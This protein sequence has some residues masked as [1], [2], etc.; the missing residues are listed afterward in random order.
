[1]GLTSSSGGR[2]AAL[3]E[4]TFPSDPGLPVVALAGSPNVG[5]STVFNALTGLRQHT[6]NWTGKTV[7]LASGRCR[8]REL[9]L[10]DLPGCFSLEPSSREE[11]VARDFLISGKAEAVIAVADASCLERTLA[12][13]LAMLT[14]ARRAVLLVNLIDEAAKRGVSV[15]CE[16]LSRRLGVPVVSCSARSGKGLDLLMQALDEVMAGESIDEGS[17]FFTGEYCRLARSGASD[18]EALAA[19]CFRECT[20]L[21]DGVIHTGEPSRRAGAFLPGGALDRFVTGRFTAFPLMLLMLLGIFYL[22]IVGANL[23]SELLSRLFARLEA[24]LSSLLSS[25]NAAPFIADAATRGVFRTVSWV[26]SVMLPPMAIFFPLFTLLEDLGFLPRAAFVTDRLFSRAG[27]NGR[28]ALTIAMGFGCNAAGVVGCRIIPGERERLTAMLTNSL[29]PCNGRFPLM[30]ALS[31]IFLGAGLGPFYA[32][33]TLALFVLLA[34]A[35]TLLMTFILSRTLPLPRGS[36]FLLELPPYRPPKVVQTLVRSVLDRTL[37][38]FSRALA[39]AAPAGLVIYLLAN[40]HIGE[41]S[42]LA[43]FCSFLDP[44]AR[45]FG[46]DGV[47][48]AAFILGFPA[49]EIVLPIMLM[50]YTAGG[51][52]TDA[53]TYADIARVLTSNGW[54][55]TTALSVILFSMFHW[56]CSTT[57]L[58]IRREAGFKWMLLGMA[59]PTAAGLTILALFNG[60]IRLIS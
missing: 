39:V 28:Q 1:M 11:E 50:A 54:T 22:T 30:I 10:V 35:V 6:G 40:V 51:S 4:R 8:S 59:L 19:E 13:V 14:A 23:P 49:N 36:G 33:G 34:A 20:R 2:G 43:S 25:I 3:N 37:H 45:L 15:D 31:A 58:T 26:A 7:A 55:W 41:A 16:L 38:V 46:L 27:T 48:L 57:C 32:A 18:K 44:F 24:L 17:P 53:G 21:L 52:L 12:P 9:L 56:P 42:L 47:I 60:F 5:K 29:V